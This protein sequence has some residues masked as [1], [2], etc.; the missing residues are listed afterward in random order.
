MANMLLPAHL[1]DIARGIII[2]RRTGISNSAGI[3]TVVAERILDVMANVS[4]LLLV[5]VTV[6]LPGF[7]LHL[8]ARGWELGVGGMLGATVAIVLFLRSQTDRKILACLTRAVDVCMPQGL[9]ACARNMVGEIRQGLQVFAC[10][11]KLATAML[12]SLVLWGIL[13]ILNYLAMLALGVRLPLH[14]AFVALLAQT[15]G[16]SIPSSPGY[17]GTFHMATVVG[18]S[19]YGLDPEVALSVAL[20]VH[21]MGFMFN[22]I[23]G[24]P[25]VLYEGLS[26]QQLWGVTL[27]PR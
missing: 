7:S 26:L 15:V 16:V 13:G 3:A 6:R 5:W 25:F 1:G 2:A 23:M 10:W 18:L 9:M 14:A 17:V 11:R 20:L 4:I 19:L 22:V 24:V 27:I 21:T 12:L 8:G